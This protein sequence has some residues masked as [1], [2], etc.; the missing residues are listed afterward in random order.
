V[1]W[2]DHLAASLKEEGCYNSPEN[3]CWRLVV[4]RVPD[5]TVRRLV[6]PPGYIVHDNSFTLTST[7]LYVGFAGS[8]VNDVDKIWRATRFDLSKLEEWTQSL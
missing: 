3:P 4:I 6:P 1:T 2:G 8:N 7:H 5:W